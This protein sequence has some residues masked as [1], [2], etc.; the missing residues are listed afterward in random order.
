MPEIRASDND[1]EIASMKVIDKALA[2]LDLLTTRRVL[3]WATERHLATGDKL[4]QETH[5]W[6]LELTAGI[7]VLTKAVHH[8]GVTEHEYVA[9]VSRLMTDA[10]VEAEPRVEA[11]DGA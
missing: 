10:L 11:G 4:M 9:A 5:E 2:G 6:A 3:R 7:S 8:A 1:P